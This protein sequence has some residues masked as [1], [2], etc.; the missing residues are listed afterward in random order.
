M[1]TMRTFEES[2]AAAGSWRDGTY[3]KEG[4]RLA[5]GSSE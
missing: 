5:A 2:C 3:S 4:G 1:G